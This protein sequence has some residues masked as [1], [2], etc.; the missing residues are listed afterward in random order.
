MEWPE[1]DFRGL[2]REERRQVFSDAF[3]R[4]STNIERERACDIIRAIWRG[5]GS[6]DAPMRLDE[7]SGRRRD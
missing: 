7:Q 3:R 4:A 5:D 2:S 1:F 6:Y